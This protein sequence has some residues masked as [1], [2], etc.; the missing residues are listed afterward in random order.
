MLCRYEV[1]NNEAAKNVAEH[2]EIRRD[3]HATSYRAFSLSIIGSTEIDCDFASD[4]VPLVLQE[5]SC[6]RCMANSNSNAALIEVWRLD[7]EQEQS[8]L[9]SCD[10]LTHSSHKPNLNPFP[11]LLVIHVSHLQRQNRHTVFHTPVQ[12]L[13]NFFLIL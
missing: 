4:C 1:S 10:H 2:A 7:E 8:I 13:L 9:A 5:I 12:P 3:M 11:F 6:T